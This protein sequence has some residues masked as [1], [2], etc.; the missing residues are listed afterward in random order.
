VFVISSITNNNYGSYFDPTNLVYQNVA[1]CVP[2]GTGGVS[3]SNEAA[4]IYL[5]W[6]A[7]SSS[8]ASEPFQTGE[9]D[10]VLSAYDLTQLIDFVGHDIISASPPSYVATGGFTD[11]LFILNGM[12]LLSADFA[13]NAEFPT[14]PVDVDE[15]IYLA[16]LYLDDPP[17]AGLTSFYGINS[18]SSGA[19][20]GCNACFGVAYLF[21]R[22]AY[23]R[24]GGDTYLHSLVTSGKTGF[25][26]LQQAFGGTTPQS[27]ISDFAVAMLASGQDVTSDPRFNVSGFTTYANYVDQ[28]G[29]SLQ[30]TGPSTLPSQASGTSDQYVETLGTFFYLPI[31]NPNGATIKESDV[32]GQFGLAAA[33]EEF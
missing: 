11:D 6:Q 3:E 15:N 10:I 4:G 25:G 24:F 7:G 31:G 33:L 13:I 12:G 21:Q 22:Y 19:V 9:E 20:L 23:D 5:Q 16:S 17:A 1:N 2:S 32:S 30:I 14:V 28:F 18:G 27:V 8:S 26:N 29:D